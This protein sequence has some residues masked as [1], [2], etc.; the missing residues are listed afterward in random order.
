MYFPNAEQSFTM[1]ENAIVETANQQRFA[2][3]QKSDLSQLVCPSA[4]CEH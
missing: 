4:A 1:E 2:D 3:Q